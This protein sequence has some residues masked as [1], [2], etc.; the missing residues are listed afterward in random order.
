VS[1][2]KNINMI[3]FLLFSQFKKKQYNAHK[4]APPPPPPP[5]ELKLYCI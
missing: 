1:G 5:Q 3:C 2:T 4:I